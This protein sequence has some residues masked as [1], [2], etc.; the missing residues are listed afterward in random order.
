MERHSFWPDFE[1]A[2]Y[3]LANSAINIVR[4]VASFRLDEANFFPEICEIN[5]RLDV[6]DNCY[7]CWSFIKYA[8]IFTMRKKLHFFIWN[9]QLSIIF[10]SSYEGNNYDCLSL[11]KANKR[12]NMTTISLTGLLSHPSWSNLASAFP[13]QYQAAFLKT[14]FHGASILS[15][16]EQYLYQPFQVAHLLYLMVRDDFWWKT[17]IPH[18]FSLQ[19]CGF[20]PHSIPHN[21]KVNL[22]RGFQVLPFN[23]LWYFR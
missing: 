19:T 10:C 20:L 6:C 1:V 4:L 13:K 22:S 2:D 23:F 5:C 8:F 17:T 16:H 15:S 21:F 3:L 9:V 7:S 11:P 12:I 18:C 14:L